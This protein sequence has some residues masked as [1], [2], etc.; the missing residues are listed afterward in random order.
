MPSTP[1]HP[2]VVVTIRALE[3]FR[4][5]QLR[6]P[7]LGVQTFVRGLCDLH[8]VTPRPYLGSQFSTAFDVYLSIRAEIDK[9]VKVALGRDAPNWRLRN[10][11]PACLYKLEGEPR[12]P[13]AFISTMDGNNSLKRFWCRERVDVLVDGAPVPGASKQWPGSHAPDEPQYV[14]VP[15]ASKEQRDNRQAPGDHYLSRAEV[16]EWA[17]DEVDEV[18]RGF[19]PGA[20]EDED[21]GAGC[22]ERWENMKED[23]TARA[24]GMY[25][26]TGIFPALC[27][28]GFV[29]VVV[30]MVQ[31]GEL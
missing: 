26:E 12:L 18:M 4:V 3:L 5:I 29:L 22:E 24:W 23:V 31:S 28:H 8:S 15:G 27:R 20:G 21:E 30:D 17:K 14:S 19:V 11:C 7:R 10:S 6:C 1:L 25:D 16:N 9:H 2:T 13:C